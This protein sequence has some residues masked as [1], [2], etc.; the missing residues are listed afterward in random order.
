MQQVKLFKG[1]ESDCAGL[2]KEINSWIRQSG[3]KIVSI[4][5]NIAPQSSSGTSTSGALGG[6]HF[7]AS[8]ILVIVVYERETS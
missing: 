4:T 5:G 2:E 3:A 8:D 1:I 6:G 7:A